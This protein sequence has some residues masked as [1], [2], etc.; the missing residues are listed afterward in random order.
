MYSALDADSSSSGGAFRTFAMRYQA[1]LDRLNIHYTARWITLG[2]LFAIYL[3]RVIYFQGWYIVTYGLGI[4]VLNL[5]IAFLSPKF[6]PEDEDE[7]D[8]EDIDLTST[9]PNTTGLNRNFAAGGLFGNQPPP[10]QDSDD[11]KPFIRR[12]PEFKFWYSLTKAI[13]ISLFFTSTR[14]F[15]I[16]VYWPIL[17]GY[18]LILFIVT[19]RKQIRHMIKH[20]YLPFTTGKKNYDR[21]G[22]IW[23]RLLSLFKRNPTG[24]Q[25]YLGKSIPTTTT[26]NI[27]NNNAG[28]MMGSGGMGTAAPYSN[29]QPTIGLPPSGIASF[30]PVT[31]QS[32]FYCN[33]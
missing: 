8:D 28:F 12:L 10:K 30:Q 26:S 32:G 17:L 7:E 15:D 33:K 2:V 16:P 3:F 5:L 1:F 14:I 23:A 4:Y 31:P 24:K 18:W 11:I 6:D 22:N 29:F 20:K 27:P 19:M 25:N 13:I 9:L 21:N